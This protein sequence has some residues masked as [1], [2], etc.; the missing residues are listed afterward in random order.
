MPRALIVLPTG[1]Y[2]AKDFVAAAEALGVELAIAS[3]EA[4][5]LGLQDRFVAIDCAHPEASA[6]ALADLAASTPIDAIVA[7]D[8]RGVV[9][10]SLASE[11]LG[12]QSNDP[13]AAAATRNKA[14]MRRA[15]AAGEVPQPR[16]EVITGATT[17][18][19]FPVVVKPL[20][21][22]ASRGVIRVDDEAGLGTAIERIRRI[23]AAAGSSP[24]EPLLCESYV[25]GP[26]V[27]VEGILW[28]GD[29]EVLAVFDKPDPLVG[30]YF[31]ETMF[32]TPSRHPAAV[33]E[34]I[35]NATNRA[36]RALG[37]REGPIHAEF[38]LDR[39]GPVM[40]EMAARTIGGLCGRS[41]TFGLLDTP[42]EVL[43]LRHALG[44]RK[45][46]LKRSHLA[47]GVMMIPVPRRGTL[48]AVEGLETAGEV[49]SITGIE[50]TAP[51]GSTVAP[52]PE[53]DRYLGFIFARAADPVTVEGALRTAHRQLSFS[54]S[55]S[56]A[57]PSG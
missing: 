32:V 7:A 27:S 23:L 1:T 22:N 11:R 46:G 16:F 57:D 20:S 39:R 5:P 17:S 41:L 15:L 34:E 48:T 19:P 54:I 37:L 52:P 43:V 30:P 51:I 26:E 8:D 12:L 14:M 53:G 28:D 13:L 47:A 55:P 50:I 9:V 18:I 4:P 36:A 29:L 49:G 24:S 45:E 42:L 35:V 3:E 56:R 33:V 21:L 2:R 25:D 10:A 31:E 6:D 40:I 44:M 38:R